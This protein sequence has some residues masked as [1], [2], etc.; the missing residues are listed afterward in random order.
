MI[1]RFN[2]IYLRDLYLSGKSD[3]NI[4]FSLKSSKGI[5]GLLI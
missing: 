1:I 4:G 3:K 5:F 2:E